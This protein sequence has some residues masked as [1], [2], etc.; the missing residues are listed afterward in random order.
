[1]IWMKKV[2]GKAAELNDGI[3]ASC[4]PVITSATPGLIDIQT[5]PHL[6]RDNMLLLCYYYHKQIHGG[7]KFECG[8]YK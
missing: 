2:K 3:T 1:M 6:R 5:L 7:N 4:R 8:A